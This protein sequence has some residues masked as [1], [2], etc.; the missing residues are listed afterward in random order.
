MRYRWQRGV[1]ASPQRWCRDEVGSVRRSTIV[2]LLAA[3]VVMG[4]LTYLGWSRQSPSPSSLATT[5][6]LPAGTF[7][8]GIPNSSE[9][10]GYAPPG[11]SALVGYSRTYVNDFSTSGIPAGWYTFHGQPGGDPGGQFAPTHVSV[12]KGLL[13]LL[14]ARDRQY[15]NR[16]V[17]GGLCQCGLTHT[18]GAYFVRSR[19]TGVGP[20]EVELLW[21]GNNQWPPEIDFN[22]TPSS[23]QTSATVHWGHANYTQQ[24][25]TKSVS[26]LTWNT[27]GVVWTPTK[28]IYVVN[29]R[30]WGVITNL[31]AI[32]RIPMRLD[33]EQRTECTIHQQ[34]PSA[35]VQMQVD[36]VAEYYPVS[37]HS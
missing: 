36:W 7:P 22:E 5:T 35:P 15:Q 32:P 11:Q 31:K 9:P 27:W 13:I 28:I 14:A 16:W 30:A 20:N 33:L 37:S 26:M 17:T 6:T 19:V 8:V 29:G 1:S 10:S 2:L 25:R 23:H 21:P 4:M 34:C 24:W 3:I 18:Y 12:K